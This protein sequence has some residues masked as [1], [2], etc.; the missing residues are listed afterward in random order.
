MSRLL[1]G[2]NPAQ[3]SAVTATEGPILVLAGPGSGKTRVLTHRVAYL[4]QERG[5]PPWQVMAVTFTNKAA[6]EMK[7]R[8]VVLLGDTDLRRLTIGTFHAICVRILRASGADI[9]VDSQFVIYDRDDQISLVKRSMQEADLDPKQYAP[10]AIISAIAGV[11]GYLSGLGATKLTIPFFTENAGV[12]VAF[13]PLLAGGVL[14]AAIILGLVAS[15]YPAFLAGNL[16]PNEALR[17]L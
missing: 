1:E 8:L 12:Q 4:V 5:V 7:D 6:N 2:L 9:G 11:L 17:T 3:Q 10:S 13:D 15:M 14:S 16:D